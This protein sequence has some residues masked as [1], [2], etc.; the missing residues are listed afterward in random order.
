[1]TFAQ[2]KTELMRWLAVYCPLP[3]LRTALYRRCGVEIGEQTVINFGVYIVIPMSDRGAERGKIKIG[4][5]V[6]IATNTVIVG[7]SNPNFSV[8]SELYPNDDRPIVIGDD[9]W[10]GANAVILPGVTIG[11]QSIVAAGAVVNRDVP[12]RTVVA[13]IPARVIKEL[14]R[15]KRP[16]GP[17]ID[18]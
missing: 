18:T 10:I 12:P 5:R 2:K 16:D 7:E 17:R 15:L 1:M 11:E 6:A 4:D 8:L 9:V 14:P 13:G 3:A